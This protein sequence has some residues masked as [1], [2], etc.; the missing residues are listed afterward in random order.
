MCLQRVWLQYTVLTLGG[1]YKKI[2]LV[3]GPD[4]HRGKGTSAHSR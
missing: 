4:V 2:I 3:A 1:H